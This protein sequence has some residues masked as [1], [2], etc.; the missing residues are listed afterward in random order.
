MRWPLWASAT[1]AL[2]V[3]TFVTVVAQE[4][5]FAGFSHHDRCEPITIPMCS[6]I[7]YNDTIFPNLMGNGNQEEAGKDMSNY[8]PLIKI[9]C[10][11]DIQLFLCSLYAPVCTIL[12]YAIPPCRALCLSAR[13]GCEQLMLK[14]DFSWPREFEC[15]HFPV[16]GKPDEVCVGDPDRS[17]TSN[18]YSSVST[19][20]L[21]NEDLE[22]IRTASA[23]AG[24]SR[25]PTRPDDFSRMMDFKC[26]VQLQMPPELEY[27]LHIGHDQVSP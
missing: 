22:R 25:A 15:D 3:L 4:Y 14:F 2:L 7:A 6:G 9:N 17:S 19:P 12:D 5:K 24:G 27:E 10:S 23:A 26:P 11:P 13:Q 16:G 8:V 21:S 1:P 18:S 20:N